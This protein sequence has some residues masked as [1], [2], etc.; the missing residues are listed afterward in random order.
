M[1]INFGRGTAYAALGMLVA[2]A[3]A[4]C[5]AAAD[6]GAGTGATNAATSLGNCG[7][8]PVKAPEDPSGVLAKM[9]PDVRAAYNGY[10]VPITASPWHN[11]K[12]KGS[13]PYD[14]AIVYSSTSVPYQKAM[15]D[16]V[17]KALEG[18]KFV[19]DVSVSLYE[20]DPAAAVRNFQREHPRGGQHHT[21]RLSHGGGADC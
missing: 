1:E 9:P 4:A 18:S 14:V 5:G 17:T 20:T 2:G 15:L 12:P 13:G 16:T 3:L 8:L 11:F 10:D 21:Q 19:G 6:S 7:K